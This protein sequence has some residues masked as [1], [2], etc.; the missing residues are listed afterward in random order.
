MRSTVSFTPRF[1]NF[2]PPL[3]TFNQT[4]SD[5]WIASMFTAAM[6][7]ENI[8]DPAIAAG[9]KIELEGESEDE[10]FFVKILDCERADEMAMAEFECQK[11]LM[12]YIPDHVVPPIAWGKFQ[13]DP[14]KAFYL[15]HF[16]YLH[17]K[18]PTTQQLLPI[19]KK[20]HLSSTSPTGK[21]G[22]PVTTFWGPPPMDN[23]WTDSW[24][25]YFTRKFRA[26]LEYGQQPHGRDDELCELGEQPTGEVSSQR[27]AMATSGTRT[28][29]LTQAPECPSFS[30]LAAFTATTKSMRSARNTLGQEFVDTY[31]NEVGASE[32]Q[33]DFDDRNALYSM[34]GDLETVGMWPQWR[35]LLQ[36]VK[37]EMRRL[38]EKHH[39]GFAGFK[40][41]VTRGDQPTPNM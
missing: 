37:D 26:A 35:P 4:V 13:G 2:I 32:P 9:Y 21:F 20:L 38:L 31:K 30:T 39:D 41:V 27:C 14:T 17:E 22:F 5:S 6:I 25:E 19:V 36:H 16:R 12:Q 3:P 34:R 24:E 10:E 40:G 1:V 8:L 33:E 15:T 23:S 18:L 7:D 11:T 28:S 29:K